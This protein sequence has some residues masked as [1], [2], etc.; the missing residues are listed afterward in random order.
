MLPLGMDQGGIA[1]APFD[2]GAMIATALNSNMYLS[3]LQKL[4]YM[5]L[6]MVENSGDFAISSQIAAPRS[7]KLV[8]PKRSDVLNHKVSFKMCE[9]EML[10]ETDTAMLFA[11]STRQ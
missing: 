4:N 5:D 6:Q 7:D 10:R 9:N 2:F 8:L 1:V 3:L 11:F